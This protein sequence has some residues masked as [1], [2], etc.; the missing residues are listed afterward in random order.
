MENKQKAIEKAYGEHWEA[1][2]DYVDENGWFNSH[3]IFYFGSKEE[4]VILDIVCGLETEKSLDFQCIRPKSLQGIETNNCW[5][6]IYSDGRIPNQDVWL[7]DKK[8]VIIFSPI[9]EFIPKE[10]N[11]THYQPIQKPKPPIY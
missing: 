7:I 11:Y 4:K 2:K 5:Q 8:G 6:E 9:D 3:Q 1:V 10:H